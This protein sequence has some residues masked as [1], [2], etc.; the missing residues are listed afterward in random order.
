L[1]ADLEMTVNEGRYL[2]FLYRKRWEESSRV[3]TTVI[4]ESFGVRPATVTEMLQKLSEKG[5]LRYTRYRGADLTEK[6]VIEAKRL[7][8]RHRIL[9]V[10]FVRFLNY[11][12]Q[13]ACE[14]A[15][16]LDHYASEE[17]ANAICQAYGHPEVCPC[18]KSIF[19]DRKCCEV[20]AEAI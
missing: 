1:K 20:R 14:E 4:A 15:T 2:K 3:G 5:L 8:R 6:G 11:S 10:L 12:S 13:K 18:D 19:R 9:E 17:L 16:E 7:L